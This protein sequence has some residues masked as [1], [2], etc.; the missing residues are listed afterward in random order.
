M[1]FGERDLAGWAEWRAWQDDDR[2]ARLFGGSG[3]R[4][5]TV[6]APGF[7][8]T[9]SVCSSTYRMT[10]RRRGTSFVDCGMSA[11]RGHWRRSLSESVILQWRASLE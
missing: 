9:L 3:R 4:T 2:L 6:I 1:Q 8:P 11:S 10:I 7:A 5:N